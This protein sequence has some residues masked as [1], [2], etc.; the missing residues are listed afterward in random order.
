M[1]SAKCSAST[2]SDV[3]GYLI[4]ERMPVFPCIPGFEIR[5]EFAVERD[6]IL[7]CRLRRAIER[8]VIG[9][10][11]EKDHPAV[12]CDPIQLSHPDLWSRFA[13]QQEQ[14][15]ILRQSIRKF[16][17]AGSVGGMPNDPQLGG[18]AADE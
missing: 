17:I 2:R 7:R 12:L 15:K 6:G 3:P 13:Q 8:H 4:R 16:D 1:L 9:V 11:I 14:G 5:E 10:R 18:R